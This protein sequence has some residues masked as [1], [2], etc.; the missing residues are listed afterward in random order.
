MLRNWLR[1]MTSRRSA[2]ARR[3]G[4]TPATLSRRPYLEA[5]EDRTLPSTFTVLN[6][7]DSGPGSLRQAILGADAGPGGD[8]IA[9]NISGAGVHTITPLS[10]LPALT[11]PGTVLDGYTQRATAARRSSSWTARAPVPTPTD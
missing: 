10:P 5:L 2:A 7:A 8:T 11:A 6:L 4:R 3:Q 9:F 1:P